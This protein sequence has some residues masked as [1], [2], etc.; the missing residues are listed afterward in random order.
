MGGYAIGR[1]Y[2]YLLG[3]VPTAAA[4]PSLD[5]RIFWEAWNH[6]KR[7]FYRPLD[8]QALVRGAVRGMLQATGDD[9]TGYVDPPNYKLSSQD[10]SGQF[11][12]IGAEIGVRDEKVVIVA[13][14]VGSPAEKAGLRPGDVIR[15]I[16]GEDASKLNVLEAAAKIRGSKGTPVRLTIERLRDDSVLD[17]ESR[18]GLLERLPT[19]EQ[20]LRSND[21]KAAR[22]A[23]GPVSDAIRALSGSGAVE[24]EITIV[25]DV[26]VLARVEQRL[27]GDG[28]GYIR[29]TQF[30]R[31]ASSQ[32]DEALAA[33]LEQKPKALVLDLRRNSGGFVDEAVAIASQF[34][35]GGTLVFTEERAGGDRREWKARSGGRALD[36]PLVVLI[37]R[38]TASAAEI[39]AG[40][41]QDH[42]RANLVG[43][44][45]FGKGTEQ[46]WHE[47]SDG[48]GIRITIA[49]W[50]TPAGT[51]V[52]KDGLAPDVAVADAD[53]R[54]PDL[55]LE[56]AITLLPS[57]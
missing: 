57:R 22:E 20:A 37:D 18:R 24:L 38:G 33:L 32:F 5:L 31:N 1:A 53:P 44:T 7:E 25:R 14:F 2:P 13:P 34:L 52:Q 35:P 16:D 12:G 9:A 21:A 19:L 40:A 10:L 41:I 43:G 11:E 51:W 30:S 55:Q 4:D 47:L 6:L 45:S 27:L 46:F 48:S 39:L 54:P 42:D 28:I 56:R 3:P 29:F 26:I 15:K 17:E 23:A 50:L 36:L 49:R 8:E